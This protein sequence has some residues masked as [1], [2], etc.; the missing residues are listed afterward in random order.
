MWI[1][2]CSVGH[3]E[4]MPKDLF[5]GTPSTSMPDDHFWLRCTWYSCIIKQRGRGLRGRAR[6]LVH[7]LL[8]LFLI[9]NHLLQCGTHLTLVKRF[10]IFMRPFRFRLD[11]LIQ[12]PEDYRS[13]R[14]NQIYLIIHL[15]SEWVHRSNL[16]LLSGREESANT[17]INWLNNYLLLF[18][19][20]PQKF[21]E[22]NQPY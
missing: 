18:Y 15:N 17:N 1:A 9:R 3:S 2:L 11:S 10:Q 22:L 6:R 16:E 5:L 14:Y 4:E 19:A 12:W 20:W 13:L 7:W 8:L 21:S